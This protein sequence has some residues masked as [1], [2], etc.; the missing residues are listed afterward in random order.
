MSLWK[1][2]CSHTWGGQFSL[3]QGPD[4]SRWGLHSGPPEVRGRPTTLVAPS[5][6]MSSTF[7]RSSKSRGSFWGTAGLQCRPESCQFFFLA[8]FFLVSWR[9]ITL[10]YCSGFLSH[11]HMNQPWIYTYSPSRSPLPP[12]SPMLGP[13][14]LGVMPFKW[15]LSCPFPRWNHRLWFR[16]PLHVLLGHLPTPF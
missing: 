15:T 7:R 6:H 10:Q 9:L 16:V 2:F 1:G 14:A 12:P 3:R 5:P 13:G 4:C 11:I 8:F